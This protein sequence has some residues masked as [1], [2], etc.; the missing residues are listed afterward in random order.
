MAII[1]NML[2]LLAKRY[3]M[4]SK[5]QNDQKKSFTTQNYDFHVVSKENII[6]LLMANSGFNLRVSFACLDDLENN[7]MKVSTEE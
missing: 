2:R 1:L 3:L 4:L 5:V 7:F 6:F